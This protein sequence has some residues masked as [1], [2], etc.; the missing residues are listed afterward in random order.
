[1][2]IIC[3]YNGREPRDPSH[4][5]YNAHGGRKE[6]DIRKARIR[7]KKYNKNGQPE[8]V[9]C[10]CCG[11]KLIVDKGILREGAIGVD[12]AWD[13]FSEKDG[14]VHH[15]DLCEDCYDELVSGFKIPVEIEERVELL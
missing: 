9:I 14:Q 5:A 3:V 8:A 10:N 15:F 4:F 1:M 13:Y 2:R 11:K 12:F 7:M 6:A